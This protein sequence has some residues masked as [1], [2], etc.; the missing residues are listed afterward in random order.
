[1]NTE[2]LD[3][4]I[5]NYDA[6]AERMSDLL[7]R[8]YNTEYLLHTL[9]ARAKASGY[10]GFAEFFHYEANCRQEI[11]KSI[12]DQIIMQGKEIKFNQIDAIPSRGNKLADLIV[13]YDNCIEKNKVCLGELVKFASQDVAMKIAINDIVSISSE[14]Y[15]SAAIGKIKKM[16]S[17]AVN[18]YGVMLTIDQI[19]KN[20]YSQLNGKYEK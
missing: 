15:Q 18:N 10:D 1:M 19:L 6:L 12:T 9:Q 13:L 14:K 3:N 4:A 20:E 7:N 2:I 17:K 16:L 8:E 5:V 11:I